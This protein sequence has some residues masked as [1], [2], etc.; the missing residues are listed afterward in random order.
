M[1]GLFPCIAVNQNKDAGYSFGVTFHM[2]RL[3]RCV[4]VNQNYVTEPINEHV[5]L[6]NDAIMRCSVPS[7][8][9]DFISVAGWADNSGNEYH[10]Q[11]FKLGNAGGADAGADLMNL[12]LALVYKS[13][14]R[15]VSFISRQTCE[16]KIIH[17][18]LFQDLTI[19][20]N[21]IKTIFVAVCCPEIHHF[22]S[23][24]RHFCVVWQVKCDGCV[25][26]RP[27]WTRWQRSIVDI[28]FSDRQ[29][30]GKTTSNSA[31]I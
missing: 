29:D 11:D 28:Q 13:K 12:F 24:L 30:V 27:S 5:I 23:F 15:V 31:E 4:A 3:F 25:R 8:M 20:I 21:T 19:A 16:P 10:A 22:A 2:P 17:K 1:P 7:F 14:C 18:N 6:G 9:S 26:L